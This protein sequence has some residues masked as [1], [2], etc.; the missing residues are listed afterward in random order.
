MEGEKKL[1]KEIGGNKIY[2][3]LRIGVQGLEEGIW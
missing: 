1:T 2:C 3:E